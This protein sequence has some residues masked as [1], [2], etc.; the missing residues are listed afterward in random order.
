MGD[1]L[2]SSVFQFLKLPNGVFQFSFPNSNLPNKNTLIS[3]L[4]KP[5]NLPP[6]KKLFP[7]QDFFKEEGNKETCRKFEFYPG[8]PIFDLEFYCWIPST[9]TLAKLFQSFN[10]KN[11]G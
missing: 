5:Q 8:D 9:P 11:F 6:S 10:P 2:Q 3:P 7:H 4:K 1:Y